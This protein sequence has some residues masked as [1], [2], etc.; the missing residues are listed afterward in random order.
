MHLS[1]LLPVADMP[2]CCTRTHSLSIPSAVAYTLA[3]PHI[4]EDPAVAEERRKA[5]ARERDRREKE[6]FEQRLKE[7]DEVMAGCS[8]TLIIQECGGCGLV[9]WQSL[10]GVRAAGANGMLPWLLSVGGQA[11]RLAVPPIPFSSLF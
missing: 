7:K 3:C 1:V 2:R 4:A 10:D 8:C 5:E 11:P 6:E 9:G